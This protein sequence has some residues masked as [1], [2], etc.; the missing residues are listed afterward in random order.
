MATTAT[1]TNLIETRVRVNQSGHGLTIAYFVP[2]VPNRFQDLEKNPKVF[3]ARP[4]HTL[5]HLATIEITLERPSELRG[6]IRFDL[7]R[8]FEGRDIPVYIPNDIRY[9]VLMTSQ[10]IFALLAEQSI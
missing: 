10:A 3:L 7:E 6:Y 9:H 4:E 1:I 5:E 8:E 2:E